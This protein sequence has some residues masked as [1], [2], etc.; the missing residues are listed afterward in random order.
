MPYKETIPGGKTRWRAVVKVDGHRYQKKFDTR[1]DALA[2]E[3]AAKKEVTQVSRGMA[4]SELVNRY[5]D[6]A[7]ARYTKKTYEEKV[8]VAKSLLISLGGNDLMV[9]QVTPSVVDSYLLARAAGTSN[10]SANRDRKNLHAMFA[11]GMKVLDLPTNPIAKIDR[12]AHDRA[13][14]YTPPE[15]D[16]LKV[17]AVAEGVDRVFLECYLHT[18]ARRSEI[19]GLT[20][21]DVNFD[22]GEIRLWTRKTKDGSRE[23]EWLP[24]TGKLQ[25]SLWWWW[26]NRTIPG[27]AH[28]FVDDHPGP[29]YGKPYLVRRRYLKGLC[30][31]AG[32]QPFG[33]HAIRRY[34][35][36]MLA[37][38]HKV[39]STTIQTAGASAPQQP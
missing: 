21:E 26:E 12:F 29:H 1:K 31:R 18:G 4:F 36:S 30:A 13:P 34:V 7:K 14:Q 37:D 25:E 24:M 22:R 27:T 2:W 15:E 19:F 23:G 11:W 20:W 3:Q 5:L 6:H 32:V 17:L 8:L 9:D 10:N 28:V 38:V 35:A 39:S 33:F 16:I